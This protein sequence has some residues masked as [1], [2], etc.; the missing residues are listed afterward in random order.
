MIVHCTD[1]LFSKKENEA[2]KMVVKLAVLLSAL[3]LVTGAAFAK[4]PG[5]CN[6]YAVTVTDVDS[7]ATYSS[8]CWELC[9]SGNH[10][11][12]YTNGDFGDLSLYM[13]GRKWIGDGY[14]NEG[15]G[16][17][18][19]SKANGKTLLGKGECKGTMYWVRGKS[20]G[21]CKE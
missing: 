1:E 8:N 9:Y 2:M 21:S 16:A 17:W 15:C 11:E 4:D 12:I 20:V 13:F 6:Y 5:T 10:G 3:L 18:F 19:F 14:I 7:L